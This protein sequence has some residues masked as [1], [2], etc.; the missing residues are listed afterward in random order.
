MKVQESISLACRI[1]ASNQQGDSLLGHVSRRCDV[2]ESFWMKA[3]GYGLEEINAQRVL[4]LHFDGTMLEGLG[5]RHHEW[6][7]HAEIYRRR[8]D[9]Q[10]I[11][12]THAFFASTLSSLQ[13]ELEPLHYEGAL[14]APGNLAHFTRTAHLVTT[15]TMGEEIATTLADRSALLLRNHG[16]ITVA[17]TLEDAC[18]LALHLERACE[19]QIIALQ[20]GVTRWTMNEEEVYEKRAMYRDGQMGQLLWDYYQRNLQPEYVPLPYYK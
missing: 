11:V 15:S 19:M 4:R 3:A 14:F 8:P 7:L 6:P 12:H 5:R 9:V 17:D 13:Q 20:T 18:M 10:A 2:D 1:L 16:L